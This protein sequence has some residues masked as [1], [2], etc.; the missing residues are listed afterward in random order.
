ML[1]PSQKSAWLHCLPK[2]ILSSSFL[3]V[4]GDECGFSG[5]QF[6]G[7]GLINGMPGGKSVWYVSQHHKFLINMY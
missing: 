4:L 7:V 3:D 1:T 2:S 6:R 5:E